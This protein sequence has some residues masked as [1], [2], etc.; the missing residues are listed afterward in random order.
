MIE[1]NLRGGFNLDEL[2]GDETSEIIYYRNDFPVYYY[3]K[4][5][6]R[7]KDINAFFY[8][9]NVIYSDHDKD[10]NRQITSGELIIKGTILEEN[11]IYEMQ[12]DENKKPKIDDM[13]LVGE[14]DPVMQTGH[15]IFPSNDFKSGQIKNPVL[16]MAIV[17]GDSGKEIVYNSIRG[18]FGLFTIN[19]DSPVTQKLYQFGKLE[20]AA[21]INSFKLTAD[22]NNTDLMRIQFSPSS[23]YID[24]AID[25]KPD[26]KTNS[27]DLNLEYKLERGILFVTFKKPKNTHYLYLNVFLKENTKDKKLNNFIFKYVNSMNKEGL[28][29]YKIVGNNPNITLEKGNDN[30]LK[31]KF[32]PIDYNIEKTDLEASIIYTVKLITSKPDDEYLNVI[33]MS[34]DEVKAKQ[35]KHVDRNQITVE[36][37]NVP[38]YKYCEVIATIT[39][40]SIIEYVAY[41]AVNSNGQQIFD[42]MPSYYPPPDPDTSDTTDPS[43][44]TSNPDTTDPSNPDNQKKGDDKTGV[45]VIIG[46]SS[47]LFVIVI[48]L[49]VAIVM[50]NSKNKDLLNQVNK[51]SFVQSGAGG[52]DDGNLLLDNQNELD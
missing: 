9:H 49:V 1:F 34:E 50:Y 41:Q 12:K 14:Y 15:I 30:K 3:S 39:Q 48:V 20:N 8:L 28:F 24:F 46:V 42:Y 21:T 13:K 52:K 37:E 51:I 40:G 38:D 11:Q 7:D 27:S 6:K 4:I 18:E 31:V 10:F 44:D 47:V 19:G 25:T 33:S 45:Y 35:F 5:F 16:F 36:L 29:E 43:P 26:S 17:K 32:N 23:K 2:K 22:Y